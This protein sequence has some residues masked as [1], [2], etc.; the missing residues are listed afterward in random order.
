VRVLDDLPRS[1]ESGAGQDF[2]GEGVGASSTGLN[3][4]TPDICEICR[5]RPNLA[6]T[7]GRLGESQPMRPQSRPFRSTERMIPGYTL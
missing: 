7:S 2:H 6:R 1:V 4:Y 3:L 5:L